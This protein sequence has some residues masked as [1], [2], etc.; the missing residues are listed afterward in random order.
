MDCIWLDLHAIRFISFSR[1]AQ[2]W[3]QVYLIPVIIPINKTA[4][5]KP[6]LKS[7]EQVNIYK[8]LIRKV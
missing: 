3:Q 2:S 4:L 1:V 6:K 8:Y 7:L 5:N